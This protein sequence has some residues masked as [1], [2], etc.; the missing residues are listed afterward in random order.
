MS[1]VQHSFSYACM[2]S[3]FFL[4]TVGNHKN[5]NKNKTYIAS[6]IQSVY[7]PTAK[8]NNKLYSAKMLK[9]N[10]LTYSLNRLLNLHVIFVLCWCCLCVREKARAAIRNNIK[11][12]CTRFFAGPIHVARSDRLWPLKQIIFRWVLQVFVFFQLYHR[13]FLKKISLKLHFE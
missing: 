8:H 1:G 11:K 4:P 2:Y 12:N 5:L 13:R 6:D 9:R 7:E 10:N 3:L